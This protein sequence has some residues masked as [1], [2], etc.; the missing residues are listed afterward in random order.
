[1]CR[2][3]FR[4]LEVFNHLVKGMKSSVREDITEICR[5]MSESNK[6]CIKVVREEAESEGK[7]QRFLT[8]E[9]KET[10]RPAKNPTHPQSKRVPKW[11]TN[12]RYW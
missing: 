6:P 8:D 12:R 10:Q 5:Q 1:M 3:D 9:A 7:A 2:G 4:K 11:F